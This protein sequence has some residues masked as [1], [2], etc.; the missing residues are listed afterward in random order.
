MTERREG[1]GRTKERQIMKEM[2]G[3]QSRLGEP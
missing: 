3:A 2:N 1:D